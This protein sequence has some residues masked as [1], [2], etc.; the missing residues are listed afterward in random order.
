MELK[1]V[2]IQ[3]IRS[4]GANRILINGQQ[5]DPAVSRNIRNHSPDGFNWG[6]VGSGPAQAALGICLAVLRNSEFALKVYQN[7][8][9]SYVAS[10]PVDGDFDEMVNFDHFLARLPVKLLSAQSPEGH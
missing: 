8:K 5:L 7:F 4:D 10:W 9:F 3:G 2:R 1:K 6:F